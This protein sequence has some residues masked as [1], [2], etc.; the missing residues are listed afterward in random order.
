MTILKS[1]GCLYYAAINPKPKDKFNTR[2]RNC[3]FISYPPCPKY[4]KLYALESCHLFVSRDVFFI[5]HIFLFWTLYNTSAF[6]SI[7]EQLFP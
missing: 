2:S 3:V 7:E 5:K 6:K 4:Y 1:L